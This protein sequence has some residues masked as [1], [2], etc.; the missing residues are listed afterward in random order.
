M[1]LLYVLIG[2]LLVAGGYVLAKVDLDFTRKQATPEIAE[3]PERTEP[4]TP[5][6]SEPDKATETDEGLSLADQIANMQSYDPRRARKQGD[7]SE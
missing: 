2:G 1:E 4:E 7:L 5:G 3:E 6:H